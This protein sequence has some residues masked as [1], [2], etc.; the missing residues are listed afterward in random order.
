MVFVIIALVTFVCMLII[1]L[2]EILT[3]EFDFEIFEMIGQIVF[4]GLIFFL[5]II[6][7]ILIYLAFE[8]I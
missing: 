3:D 1:L 7:I 4:I 8:F 2:C 6:S 5:I